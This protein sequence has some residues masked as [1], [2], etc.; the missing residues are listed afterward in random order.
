MISRLLLVAALLSM[1]VAPVSAQPKSVIS[2]GKA[3][4]AGHG[5]KYGYVDYWLACDFTRSNVYL[6]KFVFRQADGVGS[7]ATYEFV[8]SRWATVGIDL[9]SRAFYLLVEGTW[10]G[11]P[12]YGYFVLYDNAAGG[13][14]RIAFSVSKLGYGIPW[15][16]ISGTAVSGDCTLV[17]R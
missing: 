2:Y 1:C 14:D 5:G 11:T 17:I 12:A 10:N 4:F 6:S 9:V 3:W 7:P 8:G 16:S 13:R 15:Y